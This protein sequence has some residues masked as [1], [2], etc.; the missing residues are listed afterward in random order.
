MNFNHIPWRNGH[1]S[2]NLFT[3]PALGESESQDCQVLC[4]DQK[5][6]WA[7][8]AVLCSPAIGS[9][10]PSPFLLHGCLC[11]NHTHLPCSLRL[12]VMNPSLFPY[13]P[14][15]L[16]HWEPK[17]WLWVAEL[18]FCISTWAVTGNSAKPQVFFFA[19]TH[20][21]VLLLSGLSFSP[22]PRLIVFSCRVILC[23]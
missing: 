14:P 15:T 12:Q 8:H 22:P 9:S 11:Q 16:F 2:Q 20:L 5:V 10:A 18:V 13:R 19:Y 4:T 6:H 3:N 1:I 23:N 7:S 21:C 17:I